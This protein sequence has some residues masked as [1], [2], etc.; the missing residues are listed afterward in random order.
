MIKDNRNLVVATVSSK[1]LSLN[2]GSKYLSNNGNRF[3]I[4][5]C[6]IEINQS[7]NISINYR[8]TVSVITSC[9]TNDFKCFN[10]STNCEEKER[11]P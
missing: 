5:S 8:L 9:K 4:Y 11:Y 10:S 1:L 3:S 6:C 7:I 2:N